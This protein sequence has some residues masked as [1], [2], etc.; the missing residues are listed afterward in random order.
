MARKNRLEIVARGSGSQAR[1][2]VTLLLQRRFLKQLLQSMYCLA[3]LTDS[4]NVD[5]DVMLGIGN[6]HC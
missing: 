2:L 3:I 6:S 4:T 5:V 1:T